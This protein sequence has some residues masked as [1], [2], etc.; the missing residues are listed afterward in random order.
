M[1]NRLSVILLDRLIEIEPPPR[2][3]RRAKEQSAWVQF[4]TVARRVNRFERWHWCLLFA[5]CT[6]LISGILL[7]CSVNPHGFSLFLLLPGLIYPLQLDSP[8]TRQYH[9]VGVL[10]ITY[11]ASGLTG[12]VCCVYHC[13]A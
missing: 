1:K 13:L 9:A 12:L 2:A 3:R 5:L 10:V 6:S 11:C 7:L 8:N 4:Q